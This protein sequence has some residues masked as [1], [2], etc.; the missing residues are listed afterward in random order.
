MPQFFFAGLFVKTELI[1]E[2]LRWIQYICP[3]KYGVNLMVILELDPDAP[4]SPSTLQTVAPPRHSASAP[5]SRDGCCY[6]KSKKEGRRGS[7]E[8]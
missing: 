6:L 7:T 3:L 4:V 1:P 2:Y 5:T 8:R